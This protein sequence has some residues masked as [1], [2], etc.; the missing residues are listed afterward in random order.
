MEVRTLDS[1]FTSLACEEPIYM[2]IDTQGFED[3][4][5]R[6]AEQSISHITVIQLEMAL[7][8]M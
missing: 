8:P 4:V 7:A 5:L 2:K 1:V 6:G 3:R